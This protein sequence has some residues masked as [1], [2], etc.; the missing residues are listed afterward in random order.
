V[1]LLW[2]VGEQMQER[3]NSWLSTLLS[4]AAV[5]F[6]SA[7]VL[8]LDTVQQYSPK[9]MK[10]YTGVTKSPRIGKFMTFFLP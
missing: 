8:T 7:L 2:F 1:K 5:P 6:F 9:Q 3:K 10:K 4:R